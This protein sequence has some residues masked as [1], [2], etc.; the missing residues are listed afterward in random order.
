MSPPCSLWCACPSYLV[1][2][3][4]CAMLRT[5]TTTKDHNALQP[6]LATPVPTCPCHPCCPTLHP[7]LSTAQDF[8]PNDNAPPS[9]LPSALLS[10][11][12][13]HSLTVQSLLHDTIASP[14]GTYEMPRTAAVCPTRRRSV[15]FAARSQTRMPPSALPDTRELRVV[16]LRARA[17]TASSCGSAD[18]NG[19]ANT[20]SSLAA[21]SA[22][23]YSC[24]FSN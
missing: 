17:V 11:R 22:R 12:T 21:L 10:T 4:L 16:G 24:A 1:S 20:R 5:L 19:L 14:P 3:L 8:H 18:T 9:T 6:N 13:F 23:V 2:A 15:R 7:S